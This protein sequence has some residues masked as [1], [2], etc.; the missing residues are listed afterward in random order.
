MQ[1]CKMHI[2]VKEQLLLLAVTGPLAFL[3]ATLSIIFANNVQSI[4]TERTH[5]IQKPFVLGL[6]NMVLFVRITISSPATSTILTKLGFVL[7][8]AEISGSLLVILLDRLILKV[9][10]IVNLLVS[11][12]L[13]VVMGLHYHP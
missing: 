10:Q 3:P 11:V 4:S 2:L 9:L 6:R 7:A 1:S 12:R 5:M 13:L 8:L